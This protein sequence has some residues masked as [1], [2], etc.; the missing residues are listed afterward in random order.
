[1]G[2]FPGLPFEQYYQQ[3]VSRPYEHVYA[4]EEELT[5]ACAELVSKPITV[6]HGCTSRSLAFMSDPRPTYN[7]FVCPDPLY[8]ALIA[9]SRAY[10]FGRMYEGVVPMLY[11]IELDLRALN[12]TI[13]Y[14]GLEVNP[15]GPGNDFRIGYNT[16][17]TTNDIVIYELQLGS[18]RALDRLRG[19]DRVVVSEREELIDL[20]SRNKVVDSDFAIDLF[21]RHRQ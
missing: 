20:I 5:L 18:N 17:F 1:M 10:Q 15:M 14:S 8:P 12:Y 11:Q 13:D 21:L 3:V 4:T 16:G 9:Y 2:E 19:T 6:F 7:F